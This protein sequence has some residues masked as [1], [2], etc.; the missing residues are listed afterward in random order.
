MPTSQIAL[1]PYPAVSSSHLKM[2][3]YKPLENYEVLISKHFLKI[4]NSL[5]TA[6]KLK[7]KNQNSLKLLWIRTK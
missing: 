6:L 7:E 4:P 3:P 1:S 5:V 2:L